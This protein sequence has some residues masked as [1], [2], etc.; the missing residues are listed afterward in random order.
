MENQSL[1]V[2]QEGCIVLK[3]PDYGHKAIG[4]QVAGKYGAVHVTKLLFSTYDQMFWWEGVG[5]P[6]KLV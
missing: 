1:D 4:I 6:P 3:E 2:Y 5:M